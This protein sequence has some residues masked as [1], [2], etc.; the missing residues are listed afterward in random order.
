MF[1]NVSVSSPRFYHCCCHP[2]DS[3][4]FS[5]LAELFTEHTAP[6]LLYLGRKA[7]PSEIVR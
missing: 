6:E 7:Q 5:P 4:T 1:G 2:A 3:Q